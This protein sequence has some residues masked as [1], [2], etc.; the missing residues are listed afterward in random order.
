M[1]PLVLLAQN[2]VWHAPSRYSRISFRAIHLG[3]SISCL[4]GDSKET[5]I[6]T[7]D[8]AGENLAMSDFSTSLGELRET[9]QVVED[10]VEYC[11][12]LL[13]QFSQQEG[14]DTNIMEEAKDCVRNAIE[15]VVEHIQATGEQLDLALKVEESKTEIA[16][17]KVQ[18]LSERVSKLDS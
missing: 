16:F 6:D 3:P 18:E 17:N 1:C 7:R 8:P 11:D 13:S 12:S 14:V 9:N 5:G 15:H 2:L 10:T 4:E